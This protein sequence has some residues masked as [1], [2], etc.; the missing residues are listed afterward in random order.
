MDIDFVGKMILRKLTKKLG[1]IQI[2]L[3]EQI[4]VIFY[5]FN[6]NIQ[7]LRYFE[8]RIRMTYFLKEKKNS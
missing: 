1:K 3:W 5:L 6:I 2:D 4:D 8:S 7:N